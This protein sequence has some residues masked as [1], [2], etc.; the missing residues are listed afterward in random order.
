MRGYLNARGGEFLKREYESLRRLFLVSPDVPYT[1]VWTFKTVSTYEGKHPC[2]KPQ[3]LLRHILNTSSRPDAVVLD[4][5]MGTGS[6][7]IA[8]KQSRRRFIGIEQD[9]RYCQRAVTRIAGTV[10][11]LFTE[12][13]E[14]SAIP[15]PPLPAEEL[16]LTL[17]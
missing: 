17:F 7:G 11:S 9:R 8:C 4:A 10:P 15:T 5:F 6:A 13:P 12:E 16:K 2:E 1:D 3:A 14:Q